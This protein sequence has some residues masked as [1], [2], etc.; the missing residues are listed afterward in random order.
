MSHLYYEGHCLDL[1]HPYAT[2]R[3]P[4]A[5]CSVSNGCSTQTHTNT[6]SLHR[7][8][9]HKRHHVWV[10]MW[11]C[12]ILQAVQA[13]TDEATIQKEHASLLSA[14]DAAIWLHW[15]MQ[16]CL[17]SVGFG[18]AVMDWFAKCFANDAQ[19]GNDL[20]SY[21]EMK[22]S[23]LHGNAPFIPIRKWLTVSEFHRLDW[24]LMQCTT[25]Q[26]PGSF[27]ITDMSPD[28]R[29]KPQDVQASFWPLVSRAHL[30]HLACQAFLTAQR[31]PA[32][33]GLAFAAAWPRWFYSEASWEVCSSKW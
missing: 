18:N 3:P 6:A 2:L 31:E 30:A 33:S 9:W 17:A 13:T 7:C 4:Q 21:A 26:T 5:V 22:A 32:P 25:F 23:M 14:I 15:M 29:Q 10:L 20:I 27:S 1:W 11:R 12:Y 16:V 28:W 24:I 19:D 8:Y